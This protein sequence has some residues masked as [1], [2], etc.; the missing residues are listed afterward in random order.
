MQVVGEN[1]EREE[2]KLEQRSSVNMKV[3]HACQVK[4]KK[5]QHSQVTGEKGVRTTVKEVPEP[6]TVKPK[7]ASAWKQT[8]ELEVV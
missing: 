3:G 7:S 6:L 8:L 2:E 5:K 4:Y 1:W